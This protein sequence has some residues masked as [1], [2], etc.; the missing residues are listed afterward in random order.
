[1]WAPMRSANG[2]MCVTCGMYSVQR[3]L[4][5]VG[6][7]VELRHE[8]IFKGG[9]LSRD[10]GI[11]LPHGLMRICACYSFPTALP[12]HAW[13]PGQ[14]LIPGECWSILPRLGSCRTRSRE[15]TGEG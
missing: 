9:G 3:Q 5:V 2:P 13:I 14:S 6:N 12:I 7:A 15:S 4:S 11:M 10:I 8:Q 1:M